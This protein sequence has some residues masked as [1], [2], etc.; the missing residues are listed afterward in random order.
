MNVAVDVSAVAVAETALVAETMVV[1]V[2]SA[3]VD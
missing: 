3:V 1:A 2:D